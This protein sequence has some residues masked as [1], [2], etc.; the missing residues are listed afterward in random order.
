MSFLHSNFIPQKA[1]RTIT[2]RLG[3]CKDVSTLFVA[4]C[5]E[6]GIKANLVLISTRDNG[7]NTL[8]LPSVSFN[9]C[10]SQINMN[11]KTYFL[12]LTDNKLPFGAA[13]TVDLKSDI[14]PI[15]FEDEHVG[16]KLMKMDMPFRPK[17]VVNRE[18][19]IAILNKDLLVT[20]KSVYFESFAS[21]LR[22]TYRNIGSDE[23]LKNISQ[24][25][26]SDFTVPIKV[27]DLKFTNLDNLADSMTIEYKLEIKNILQD[28]AGMKILNLPWSEKFSSLDVVT[29][30]TRKYP[31]ELWSYLPDD[32]NSEIINFILPAGKRF[33]EIPQ[34]IH[35][36]CANADYHLTYEIKTPGKVIIR[37][38]FERKTDQVT[39]NQYTAFRDFINQ[40]SESDN[41][42]YAIK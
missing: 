34:N 12:E 29:E 18:H 38:T 24:A 30:E 5:H 4:L 42:Q 23:Q 31:L 3:D 40:V 33:M 8:P 13:L 41:K 17:N 39:P 16:G 10:I 1:S 22:D 14:L 20:R 9:H 6:A 7:N 27:T 32:M 25:I 37:R 36:E 26:A 19:I 35:F 28:V 21:T 11:D 15:P 2:T